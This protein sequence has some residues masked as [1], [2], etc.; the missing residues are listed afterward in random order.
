[1]RTAEAAGSTGT[2]ELVRTARHRAA[3]LYLTR[4]YVRW[5][6]LGAGES[7]LALQPPISPPRRRGRPP[8]PACPL[9]QSYTSVAPAS[10]RPCVP[11]LADTTP[12][13]P[14]QSYARVRS[15][16][17]VEQSDRTPSQYR[18]K[19]PLY[20]RTNRLPTPELPPEL[21]P[22]RH[23]RPSPVPTARAPSCPRRGPWRHTS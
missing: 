11:P 5:R 22:C 4:V 15:T 14:R 20:N 18:V 8:P 7:T 19:R 12:L 1:M 17:A 16:N 9:S 3:I 21:P 10:Y 13:H 23:I 2:C 6:S